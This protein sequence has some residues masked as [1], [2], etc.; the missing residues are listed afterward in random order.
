MEGSCQP[1]NR[2][3]RAGPETSWAARVRPFA[4][5]RRPFRRRY[6]GP[7]LPARFHSLYDQAEHHGTAA[8]DLP[9]KGASRKFR[10]DETLSRR[11]PS[12]RKPTAVG[13]TDGVIDPGHRGSRRPAVHVGLGR[14]DRCAGAGL[15]GAVMAGT[16][17]REATLNGAELADAVLSDADLARSRLVRTRLRRIEATGAHFEDT[18]LTR[19][20]MPGARLQRAS[21]VRASLPGAILRGADLRQADLRDADFTGADL[22]DADLTGAKNLSTADFAG[23]VTKGARGFPSQS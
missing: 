11:G 8:P 5:N 17:L 4:R 7:A 19:A 14:S 16:V 9:S 1:H 15:A 10:A 2:P 21:L 6:A 3:A 13:G 12:G 20:D 23:A 22:T 18:Y